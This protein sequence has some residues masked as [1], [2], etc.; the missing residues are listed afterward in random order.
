MLFI[1][2]GILQHAPELYSGKPLDV[3]GEA[4]KT[5]S[6][7]SIWL[8]HRLLVRWVCKLQGLVFV[9]PWG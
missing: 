8:P 5:L 1:P 6:I 9:E 4:Q 7:C 3:E 2:L